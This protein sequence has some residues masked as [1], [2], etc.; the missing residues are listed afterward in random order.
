MARGVVP[1]T[2]ASRS[3]ASG[4]LP[5]ATTGDATNN[6]SV[7]NNGKVYLILKNTNGA[8]TSRTATVKNQTSA[9]GLASTTHRVYT[10]PAGEEWIRGPFPTAVYGT[11]LELD[12]SHAEVTI[13]AIQ[14]PE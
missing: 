2:T 1:V 7:A 10:I 11:L 12:V 5:A 6:H 4:A 9:D 8:S 13:R 14:V 3:S